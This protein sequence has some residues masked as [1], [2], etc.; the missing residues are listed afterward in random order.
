MGTTIW[1]IKQLSLIDERLAFCAAGSGW[2]RCAVVIGPSH[3]VTS[4]HR[5]CITGM[6][7]EVQ[8]PSGTSQTSLVAT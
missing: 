5:P 8:L 2:S 6:A 4:L 1:V 3:S 7:V